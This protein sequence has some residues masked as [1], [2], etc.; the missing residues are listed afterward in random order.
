[1]GDR[2]QQEQINIRI[3]EATK[4]A[5]KEAKNEEYGSFKYLITTSVGKE[6]SDRYVDQKSIPDNGNGE[7]DLS[8]V[9]EQLQ[10]LNNSINRMSSRIDN[11]EQTDVKEVDEK[12]LQSVGMQA[13]DSIPLVESEE[14][15][16]EIEVTGLESAEKIS[17]ITGRA[18]H[19]AE[20]IN[21][22]VEVVRKALIYIET[23]T[24]APVKSILQDGNRRWYMQK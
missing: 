17:K 13:Q 19:I 3:P 22:D 16:R 10:S 23:Q 14:K 7:V 20:H 1:M 21:Q 5:W 15:L 12:Q 6:L 11:I 18:D 9:T 8:E 2:H 4:Q 24:T